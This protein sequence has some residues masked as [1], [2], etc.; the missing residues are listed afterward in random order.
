M[1][2]VRLLVALAV[3]TAALTACGSSGSPATPDRSAG[4][5]VWGTVTGIVQDAAGRPVPSAL[6]VPTGA[7]SSAPAVPDKAV[8]TGQDGR[9]EW[10]LLP[11]TYDLLARDGARASAPV[12]VTVAAGQ[13][14]TA[15]LALRD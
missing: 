1:R 15:D 9:Y 6:V 14:T 4:P 3:I 13:R 11:G 10:Q 12:R 2:H 7:D 5:A 8:T